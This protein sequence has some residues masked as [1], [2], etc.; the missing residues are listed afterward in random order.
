MSP[1]AVASSTS[2]F[3]YRRDKRVPSIDP[4][5][6]GDPV[7]LQHR[8]AVLGHEIAV[9]PDLVKRPDECLVI[10]QASKRGGRI[11]NDLTIGACTEV[12]RPEVRVREML[13]TPVHGFPDVL[14][15]LP[16]VEKIHVETELH[17][18]PVDLLHHRQHV[19][20]ARRNDWRVVLQDER[21]PHVGCPA[22]DLTDSVHG[23]MPP[24]KVGRVESSIVLPPLE[25]GV[26]R[27]RFF[28][29]DQ[30]GP[31]REHLDDGDAEIGREVEDGPH[32]H[33]VVFPLF[34]QPPREIRQT[35]DS[36]QC[37]ALIRGHGFD[38]RPVSRRQVDRTRDGPLR[39]YRQGLE[40][41]LPRLVNLLFERERRTCVEQT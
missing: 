7:I 18:P 38:P 9:V 32:H 1:A 14:V 22:G 36:T 10:D 29:V 28:V 15:A 23:V 2:R 25:G 27:N 37:D 33:E 4:L 16:V 5:D 3:M 35:L 24:A 13:A 39:L 40:A 6:A 17:I 20:I 11:L 8:R 26:H 34:H 41:E 31:C 19:L 30:P 12:P 21:D